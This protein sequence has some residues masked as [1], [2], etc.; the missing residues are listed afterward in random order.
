M[1]LVFA[2]L[3]WIL[4]IGCVGTSLV[5]T[6]VTAWPKLEQA[7]NNV[8][9]TIVSTFLSFSLTFAVGLIGLALHGVT[10]LLL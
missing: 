9:V 5:L 3:F 2:V 10:T 6:F 7:T 4:F 8:Q 1:E